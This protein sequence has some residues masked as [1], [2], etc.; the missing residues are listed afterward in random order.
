MT[1]GCCGKAP[2]RSVSCEARFTRLCTRGRCYASR[3]ISCRALPS[4]ARPLSSARL[5]S[6]P[7]PRPPPRRQRARNFVGAWRL[8]FDTPLGASQSLLTV[9]ADGTVLFSGR[10]ARPAAEGVPS[11]S[12]APGTVSGSR[13]GPPP[14]RPPGSGSSPTGRGTFLATATDSVQATLDADGDS[15]SALQ[16]HGGRSQRDGHLRGWWDGA[17]YAHH[18]ATAGDAGGGHA[19]RLAMRSSNSTAG[20]GS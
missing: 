19:G 10:P 17:G 12:S 9:T 7:V 4:P 15:W 14:L 18:G 8:T 11:P 5:S 20:P 16:R 1:R 3:S 13:P 2:S 6:A